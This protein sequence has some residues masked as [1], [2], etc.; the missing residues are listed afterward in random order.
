MYICISLL[1]SQFIQIVINIL[2][3]IA[4]NIEP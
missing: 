2:S 1:V 3:S 4:A